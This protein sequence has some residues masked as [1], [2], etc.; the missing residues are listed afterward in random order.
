MGT[1][2][3][4][5]ASIT[6]FTYECRWKDAIFTMAPSSLHH[7][8]RFLGVSR[9]A[10]DMARRWHDSSYGNYLTDR[11][12]KTRC[13]MRL[14]VLHSRRELSIETVYLSQPETIV[15]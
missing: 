9:D 6:P 5:I 3:L 15:I 14:K 8:E 12:P 1:T 10:A 7:S 4:E 13:S 2:S 11:Q